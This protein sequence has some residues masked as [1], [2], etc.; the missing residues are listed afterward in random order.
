MNAT[1]KR[2]QSPMGGFYESATING[3]L[4][5]IRLTPNN[6]W[7]I[8]VDGKTARGSHATAD[9]ARRAAEKL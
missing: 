3:R 6:R 5:M 4:V 8:R 2:A 9:A 7:V 1:W